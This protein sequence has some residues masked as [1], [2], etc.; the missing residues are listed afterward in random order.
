MNYN[1]LI[2]DG[3]NYKI[4]IT[5]NIQNRLKT[6]QTANHKKIKVINLVLS[7]NREASFKL[8]K[9]LHEKYK[10]Y[11]VS[12]EWFEFT[13]YMRKKVIE[14]M[15][16]YASKWSMEYDNILKKS[17]NTII[18]LINNNLPDF[19]NINKISKKIKKIN[20]VVKNINKIINIT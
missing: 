4:G 5:N 1:Y 15:N 6:F 20:N 17:K 14:D 10:K 8:E 9:Y 7:E 19:L 18:K 16:K 12:V 11:N 13:N 2:S 3:I